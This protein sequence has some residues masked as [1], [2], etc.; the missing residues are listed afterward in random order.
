M[1]D[2]TLPARRDGV[3]V[4]PLTGPRLARPV[5]AVTAIDRRSPPA[6]AMVTILSE[7]ASRVQAR[8]S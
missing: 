1:H 7:Q 3:A 6:A 2:L 4:R 8:R 5:S